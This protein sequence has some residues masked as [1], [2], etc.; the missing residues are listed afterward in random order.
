MGGLTSLSE[1]SGRQDVLDATRR[2]K[3][4]HSTFALIPLKAFLKLS[5]PLVF[6][7]DWLLD[8]SICDV[9]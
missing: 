1:P 4:S 3:N 6:Q 2:G 7:L 9:M 8:G 5:K